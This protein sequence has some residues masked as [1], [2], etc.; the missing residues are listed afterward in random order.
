[1]SVCIF[2]LPVHRGL[3]QVLILVL[4]RDYLLWRFS[5]KH[6]IYVPVG[7][8]YYARHGKVIGRDFFFDRTTVVFTYYLQR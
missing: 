5:K 2:H 6:G 1:V 3:L 4:S 7:W 8:K